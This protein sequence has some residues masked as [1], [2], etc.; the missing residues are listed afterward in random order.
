MLT[1]IIAGLVVSVGS[2]IAGAAVRVAARYVDHLLAESAQDREA[3]KRW[4]MRE[5]MRE[6]MLAVEEEWEAQPERRAEI[7]DAVNASTRKGEAKLRE[8]LKRF[9]EEYPDMPHHKASDLAHSLM[10]EVGVGVL[11][12]KETADAAEH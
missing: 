8:V 4:S 9:A 2:I 1:T 11:A 5:V 12:K 7:K 10:R 6:L 3:G